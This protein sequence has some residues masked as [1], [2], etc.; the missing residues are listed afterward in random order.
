[1][2][3]APADTTE[4]DRHDT[5]AQAVRVEQRGPVTWIRLARPAAMNALNDAVLDGIEAAL[6]RS[7][8]IGAKSVVITGEGR[9]VLRGRRPEVRP[10]RPR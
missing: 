3:N 6:H 4:R 5:D 1:M 9:G 7:L 2:T 8:E 10:R